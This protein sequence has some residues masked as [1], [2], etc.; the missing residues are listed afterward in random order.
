MNDFSK[1]CILIPSLNPDEN[2]NELLG[3]IIKSNWKKIIIVDDGSTT[4]T[5]KIFNAI[6]KK[7]GITLL[8]HEVN[9]GKGASIKTGLD[10]IKNH[11]ID[12]D[13]LITVDA[14]GQHL[15]KDIIRIANSSVNNI[16]DVIFGVRMF[17]KSTPFASMFGNKVTQFLLHSI[18]SIAIS[19]SQTGLRYLPKFLLDD[20]LNLPSNRYD[21]ELDCLITIK[22]LNVN[23]IQVQIETVYIE[24]NK[25]SH[26]KGLLDSSKVLLI[27][28]RHSIISLSC[29]GF[30]IFLFA[31]FFSYSESVLFATFMARLIVL[32]F[33]FIANKFVAFRSF[34]GI[35][36]IREI[37]I[38]LFL[39]VL[40]AFLSA[41]LLKLIEGYA[42]HTILMLKVIV[43]T[44]L[45]FFAFY[46]QKN[47]IF[48]K[49]TH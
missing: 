18:N 44:C 7:Y 35:K 1:I 26:F 43:D 14:D 13:G 49:I 20:L 30:D 25:G 5:K 37:V 2:L 15:V 40:V 4:E 42:L 3:G 16:N 27:L 23:I 46:V 47:V 6:V 21:Y 48:K 24:D 22:N 10:Y 12:S 17:G 36:I 31:L 38:Y 29:F 32:P 8:T 45:F 41:I 28:V 19:D 33:Y 9:K 39:V 34:S 11:E